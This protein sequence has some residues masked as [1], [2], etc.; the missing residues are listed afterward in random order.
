MKDDKG[1]DIWRYDPTSPS[2]RVLQKTPRTEVGK[3]IDELMMRKPKTPW[4][5]QS[6]VPFRRE[7]GKM[8]KIRT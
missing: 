6:S 5:V 4:G 2:C 8:R 1:L 7:V 3:I